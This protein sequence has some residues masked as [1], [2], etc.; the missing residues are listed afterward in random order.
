MLNRCLNPMSTVYH[1]Y[2]GRGIKVCKRWMTFSKFVADM[3][4][5][6]FPKATIDRKNTNGD[7]SPNN[8]RWA[9]HKEQARNKRN[10]RLLTLDG[11]TMPMAAWCEELSVSPDRVFARKKLGWSD[12][13]ALLTPR[14]ERMIEFNNERKPM[15]VWA[16][17]LGI[18][19]S[20]VWYRLS[21]GWPV[22]AV[23]N[24]HVMTQS[25]AGKLAVAARGESSGS[26]KLTASQVVE[27]RNRYKSGKATMKKLAEEFGVGKVTVFWI[28]RRKT[29][30]HIP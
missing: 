27:I 20:T 29:W 30:K 19:W 12:R 10:N 18:K 25:E 9:T 15:R 6:P 2:G 14:D 7:Y 22:E 4:P 5:R 28:V 17:Q 8:C 26:H 13:D 21:Q 16:K 23:L 11:R 1:F 24:P 3:G